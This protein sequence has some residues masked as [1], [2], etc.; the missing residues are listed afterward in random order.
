MIVALFP[1][2]K[3]SDTE[4][5]EMS[6]RI[7]LVGL[8]CATQWGWSAIGNVAD[9][10]DAVLAQAHKHTAMMAVTTRFMSRSSSRGPIGGESGARSA[11]R[12]QPQ[13]SCWSR[14]LQYLER[15]SASDCHGRDAA[16]DG[17]EEA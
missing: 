5:H 2:A 1:T 13:Q 8:C 9:A 11:Q 15:A 17:F 10:G 3:H 4:A 12:C 16:G 14:V 6:A 7:L